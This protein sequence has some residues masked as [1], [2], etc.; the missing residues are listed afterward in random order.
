MF[1]D[2]GMTE[3]GSHGGSSEL[4]THVPIIYVDGKKRNFKSETLYGNFQILILSISKYLDFLHAKELRES[5][6]QSFPFLV[7]A[8]I[9]VR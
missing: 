2:H 5:S 8:L 1:G 9:W 6:V 3:G 4:E 7:H